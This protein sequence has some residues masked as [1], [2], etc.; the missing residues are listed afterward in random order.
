MKAVDASVFALSVTGTRRLSLPAAARALR[1]DVKPAVCEKLLSAL[2]CEV[3]AISVLVL[4]STS[5]ANALAQPAGEHVPRSAFVTY[6][7][8]DYILYTATAGDLVRAGAGPEVLTTQQ[9]LNSRLMLAKHLSVAYA[10]ESANTTS[11]GVQRDTFADA[12]QRTCGAAIAAAQALR[13]AIIEAS[14]GRVQPRTGRICEQLK[15]AQRGEHPCV[16]SDGSVIVPGWAERRRVK[17]NQLDI[18]A[19]IQVNNS[20][21]MCQIYDLST[22]GLGFS[23]INDLKRGDPATVELPNGRWLTGKV[24]WCSGTRAGMKFDTA[25][26]HDDPLLPPML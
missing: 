26:A 12:W 17:R 16:L 21:L 8:P 13:Q 4:A 14:A 24:S 7:P 11:G 23:G 19:I 2:L 15:A 6:L 18:A 22:G 5:L 20:T 9:M 3:E 25:L 1:A 10:A